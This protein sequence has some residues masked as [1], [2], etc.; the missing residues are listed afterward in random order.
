MA[1]DHEEKIRKTAVSLNH[2]AILVTGAAGFI[3]SSLVCQLLR[4]TEGTVIVGIDCMTDYNPLEL[5]EWRLRQIEKESER[6]RSRWIWIKGDIADKGLVD[7]LFH[8]YQFQ[9]TMNLAAQAGVRY[10]ITNPDS[11][12]HSNLIGFYNLLEAARYDARLE[13]FVYAS[14][15]SVYGGN[16]KVPFSTDDKVDSPVSLY[17][18]TK[19]SDE[20]MAHAYAKLYNIPTT[21]LRF[22]TVYGPAGR[23]DMFY[24]SA[25][26]SLCAGKSIQIFNYGN[27]ERDFTYIDDIVEGIL[28]VLQGAP[29]K[30]NGEDGLPVPPYA[31]YNIGGGKPE[32]LMTF[33]NVLQEELVRVRV[34][35]PAFDF[36]AH[37]VLVPMQPGDVPVTYAD[38]TALERDYG[39]RPQIGIRTGLRQFAEWYR[40][41]YQVSEEKGDIFC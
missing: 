15:S 23:T 25:A 11:Y 3:G 39:F 27:C 41:F 9:I 5:K 32:N 8:T 22:F 4:R 29:E 19:K 37:K 31:V 26:N 6:S 18:A 36:D 38:S 14:S 34:L 30:K 21:G 35:P 20:L 7:K 40:S 12:I 1:A 10:S 33:V 2:K 13:H 16:K 17:A 24:F 28:L